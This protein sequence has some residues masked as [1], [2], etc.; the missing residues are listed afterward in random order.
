MQKILHEDRAGFFSVCFEKCSFKTEFFAKAE[1]K[2]LFGCYKFIVESS[3]L[4][5]GKMRLNFRKFTSY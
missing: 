3:I 5:Q 2:S 4:R 1:I